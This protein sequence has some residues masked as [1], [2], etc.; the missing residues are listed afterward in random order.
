MLPYSLMSTRNYKIAFIDIDWTILNH[1]INDW[2]YQSIDALKQAQKE[3]MLIYLC[4]ARPYDS[5]YHT[6][7]LD[8]FDPDGIVCTNG[9][10]CFIKDKLLFSNIIPTNI[11]R[12][13][14][15]I[16]NKHHLV[17]ELATDKDR[18]FTASPN[19][20]V[21]NY[22]KVY[23]EI[24][25]HVEEYHNEGVSAI[26]LFAPEKYDE[27]L[28]KEFPKEINYLR[29]DDHGVDV[30]F[31]QNTKGDGVKRV[32]KHL[33]IKKEEAIAAGDSNDDISMLEEVGFSIAMGNGTDQLKA[34]AKVVAPPISEHGLSRVFFDYK[35]IK[36][37]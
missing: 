32:L 16:A 23:R 21:E 31:Y 34:V 9:G 8:I 13:I 7:L 19:K 18:Y 6:G 22:F 30:G 37:T 14:E 35:L 3:G 1:E 27:I 4:T 11:V 5:I 25:P 17:L 26:L 33:G 15:K 29:F 24:I 36:N 2:D 12:E 10:V 28:M 20:Y